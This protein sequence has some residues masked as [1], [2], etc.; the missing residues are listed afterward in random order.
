MA[1]ATVPSDLRNRTDLNL[2]QV[3]RVAHLRKRREQLKKQRVGAVEKV[4]SIDADIA[5]GEKEEAEILTAATP[6]FP[7]K[8]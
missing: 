5:A 3:N 1:I 7:E 4:E 2:G 6:L 8:K